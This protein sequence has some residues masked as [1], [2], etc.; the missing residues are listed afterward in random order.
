MLAQA[1]ALTIPLPSQSVHLVCFS[2]PYWAMRNYDSGDQLGLEPTPDAYIAALMSV[3][4][5]VWRVLRDDGTCWINLGDTRGQNYRF[6]DA[7]EKT[8]LQWS[9]RGSRASMRPRARGRPPQWAGIPHR[10]VLAAQEK[11]WV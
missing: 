11:G 1:D 6:G 2:P 10:F 5:E 3:M 8:S 4:S 9:N 7:V